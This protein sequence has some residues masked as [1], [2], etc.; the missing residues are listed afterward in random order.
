MTSPT[1]RELSE[2]SRWLHLATTEARPAFAEACRYIAARLR[3][4]WESP[5]DKP[6]SRAVGRDYFARMRAALTKARPVHDR[7]EN[8]QGISYREPI[9]AGADGALPAHDLVKTLA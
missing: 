2:A 8:E 6:M 1:Q 5:Q 4:G 7:R 3:G 9:E